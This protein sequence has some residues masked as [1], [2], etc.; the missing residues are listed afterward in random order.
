MAGSKVQVRVTSDPEDRYPDKQVQ[1]EDPWVELLL[2]GHRYTTD[3]L[4]DGW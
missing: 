3:T 1:L 4:L 2:G